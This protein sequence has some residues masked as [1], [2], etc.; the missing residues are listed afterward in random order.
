MNYSIEGELA[1]IVRLR[2]DSGQTCWAGKGTLIS[3]T[4][5]VEWRLKVPGGASKAV[6]RALS[7]ES[8]ALTL[9]E[10]VVDGAETIL[11][12]NQ[13]GKIIAWDLKEQGPIVA[14]RGSFVGAVGRKIEIDVMFARRAGAAIFGGAGLFLQRLSGDGTAFIHGAGDFIRYDLGPDADDVL[15][16]STGSLAAFS[17]SVD[18][19][20]E[21]VKGFR[22]IIFGGEGLFMTRLRGPGCVLLQS[23]KRT[24]DNKA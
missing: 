1:Q 15:F 20:I 23:L 18:Y 4:S 24:S 10:A 14:T 7:G 19:D 8:L 22:R 13:P 21:S 12:S 3:Y 6:R 16:V 2:L 9:V 17:S 5:G 11:T